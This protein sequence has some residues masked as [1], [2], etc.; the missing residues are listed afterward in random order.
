MASHRDLPVPVVPGQ[1][2]AAPLDPITFAAASEAPAI[3]WPRLRASLLRYKWLIALI[4]L[5]GGGAGFAIARILPPD[6]EVHSTVWIATE[7]PELR[8]TG[9]IRAGELLTVDS[10]E[11]LLRSFRILD[12]VAREQHLYIHPR[13]PEH[14]VLFA[15]FDVTDRMIPGRY[16]LKTEAA[17]RRWALL[18]RR[19]DV[20]E[21]GNAGDIIGQAVGFQW[22]LDSALMRNLDEIPFEVQLPR[23]AAID[24]RNR[25]VTLRP[26][27]SSIL[28]LQLTDE[29]PRRAARTMNAVTTEFVT[30]AEELKK[31]NLVDFADLLQ[32]QL[33][34][35]ERELKESEIA[36]EG[37][38]VGT[39][40]LPSEGTPMVAGLEITR[41]P[42]LQ[43]F[44][45]Q[46]VTHDQVSQDRAAL[47]RS[48]AAITA[49]SLDVSA[50]WATVA[51]M[52]GAEELRTALTEY[53]TRQSALRNALQVYTPEH[54]TVREATAGV[55]ALRTQTI[56][57]LSRSL[58]AQ[59]RQRETDLSARIDGASRELRQIPTRTIEELRLRRNVETRANL[60]TVLKNRYEEARLAEASATPDLSILDTATAPQFPV[61]NTTPR[62]MFMA[63]AASLG[64][65]LMLAV[66]LDRADRRF[67]YP[68]QVATDFGLGIIGAVPSLRRTLNRP[69]DPMTAA[70]MIEAFRT[71]R[72]NI[73]HAFP[74]GAPM[75]V[76]VTSPAAGDGKSLVCANLALSFAEA[77]YRTLLIDG[78]VRRG[79]LHKVF[80]LSRVP[81]LVDYLEE[82]ASLE[83]IQQPGTT[84]N[85][86][87]IPAG[88]AH[89]GAPERLTSRGL[90][91]L[92]AQVRDDYDV[93]I[94]DSAPLIAGVDS[95]AFGVVTRNML[96]VLRAGKT[97][98]RMA[99][100]R[101]SLLGRL[102]VRILGVIMNDTRNDDTYKYYHYDRNYASVDDRHPAAAPSR[103]RS[104]VR[105]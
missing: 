4:V 92:F 39:I 57:Q 1:L 81:G 42:V 36:L 102:P 17:G 59:L 49:G 64:L 77:G 10:W 73:T 70:Q 22:R 90:T 84:E 8:N 24:L 89:P 103:L 40:T 74:P 91:Q 33:A 16:E 97:D 6:Y 21:R 101:L 67:R 44:F 105:T 66:L 80:G 47:E 98:R 23:E 75:H 5:V 12:K 9:P 41:D 63:L 37:F 11:D 71:A 2:P 18:D 56:P 32:E 69:S 55:T 15:Q 95:F 29:D 60:Y 96:L 43:N 86:T 100:A 27:R 7:S 58:I 20:V 45:S 51:A 65:A 61:S 35:A 50:L 38:R 83:A 93:I 19:G 76:T 46:K 34:Y 99:Q 78:D 13:Y 68:E 52:D 72:L 85:L 54:P 104:L 82:T 88:A 48:L 94:V 79:T 25:L 31:R 30:L 62:I 87:I 3:Q 26:P 14:V 28:R 53:S